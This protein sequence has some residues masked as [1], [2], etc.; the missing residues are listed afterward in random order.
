MY[1][2]QH[3]SWAWL[4]VIYSLWLQMMLY[5]GIFGCLSSILSISA[6]LSYKSPFIYP[7]DEVQL[8]VVTEFLDVLLTCLKVHKINISVSILF[9]SRMLNEQNQLFYLMR[10]MVWVSHVAMTSSLTTW[11]WQLHTRNGKNIC[12]RLD[13]LYFALQYVNSNVNSAHSTSALKYID[14]VKVDIIF[15]FFYLL[16]LLVSQMCRLPWEIE[17]IHC[18]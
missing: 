15:L 14:E 6:F 4:T 13:I 7:K 10:E 16:A 17:V 9:R 18:W 5:G 11:L 1:P 2:L 8:S 3:E 12:I